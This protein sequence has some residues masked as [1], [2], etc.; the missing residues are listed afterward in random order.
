MI[1]KRFAS[2]WLCYAVLTGVFGVADVRS[3]ETEGIIGKNEWLFNKYELLKSTDAAQ[4]AASI[5]LIG[6]FNKVLKANGVSLALTMVPLK[7]RI[8]SEYLPDSIKLTDYMAGNYDQIGKA[9][10]AA[11]VTMIDLNT[12]FMSSSKRNSD[13]PLFL[14]L[15]HTGI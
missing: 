10:Q 13:T 9:L 2:K 14:G 11:G 1:H 3:Q 12:P 7:M 4:T 5:E 15:T 8:Y 6:R